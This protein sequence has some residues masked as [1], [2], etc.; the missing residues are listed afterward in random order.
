M[1]LLAWADI[2]DES[3]VLPLASAPATQESLLL[4]GPF[5]DLLEGKRGELGASA[6][7]ELVL[8]LHPVVTGRAERA[9]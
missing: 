6:L 1:G 3:E 2:R 9:D 8:E 5:Q 4:G 7:I